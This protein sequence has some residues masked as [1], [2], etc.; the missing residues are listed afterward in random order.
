MKKILLMT[1]VVMMAAMSVKA[2]HEEGEMTI[3]PRVGVTLSNLTDTDDS[4]MKVNICYG[5]ELENYLTD[6]FSLSAGLLFTDQGAKIEDASGDY[7]MSLYYATFP[8]TA[9]YYVL[10]GLAVKAGVQPAYRV[11]ARVEQG[12][13]KIDYDRF[14]D[15]LKV[16]YDDNDLEMNKF[17]L[18]IPVGLSYEISGITLDV[19]YNFG[20]TKLLSG[21]D[22]S[23]HNRVFAVT[24]GYKLGF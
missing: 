10:P 17:D 7:K 24:L 1:A 18:S 11:K 22:N 16:Y 13:E 15:F 5:A 2:Q 9:S 8:I 12:S 6:Q 3:Q 21:I 4:K 19:R 23:V 20:V 14:I